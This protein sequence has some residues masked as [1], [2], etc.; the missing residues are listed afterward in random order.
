MPGAYSTDTLL[1]FS[2]LLTSPISVYH[3]YQVPQEV[4]KVGQEDE[5]FTKPVANRK[6][7]IEEMFGKQFKAGAS[8]VTSTSNSTTKPLKPSGPFE[9]T[10]TKKRKQEADGHGDVEKSG[11]T[12]VVLSDEDDEVVVLVSCPLSLSL[13][14]LSQSPLMFQTDAVRC[15]LF[16]RPG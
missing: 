9:T 4:G 10:V 13:L 8:D 2:L 16:C 1:I 3:S 14:P 11:Q 7:G 5:S 15:F 12:T 6:G